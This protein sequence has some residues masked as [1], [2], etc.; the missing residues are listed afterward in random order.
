MGSLMSI[1]TQGL[2]CQRQVQEVHVFYRQN[3]EHPTSIGPDHQINAQLLRISHEL[4]P[5]VVEV[6]DKFINE[7]DKV[8]GCHLPSCA[9]YK[10]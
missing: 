3:G 2:A 7:L 1:A 4:L 6:V 10:I 9:W 5:P 8:S